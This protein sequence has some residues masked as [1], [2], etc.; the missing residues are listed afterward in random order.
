MYF[1]AYG[2]RSK[3]LNAS[4]GAV[5]FEKSGLGLSFSAVET[6]EIPVSAQM[7]T[8]SQNVPVDEISACRTGFAV[9]ALAAIRGAEPMPDSLEN[10]PRATPRRIA[11]I[12]ATPRNPPPTAFMLNASVTIRR[13]AG[14]MA[15]A[16]RPMMMKHPSTYR[17][18]MAGTSAPQTFEMNFSPPITTR[19]ISIA[20]AKPI[21][22]IGAEKVL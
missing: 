7:Q 5:N 21:V 22:H 4:S 15:E 6:S 13:T 9:F 8:V 17:N 18:A 11:V 3:A 2:I 16:L 20:S 1:P 19:R 14:R 10:S 12:M